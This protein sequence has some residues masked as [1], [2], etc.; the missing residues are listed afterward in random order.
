MVLGLCRGGCGAVRATMKATLESD[1]F[2]VLAN[3]TK[4]LLGEKDKRYAMEL[5]KKLGIAGSE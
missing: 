5:K 2:E 3:V 4:Q 1:D